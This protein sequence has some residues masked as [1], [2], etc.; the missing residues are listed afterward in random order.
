MQDFASRLDQQIEEHRKQRERDSAQLSDHAFP[1]VDKDR[2]ERQ[3]HKESPA[4]RQV[5]WQF[6]PRRGFPGPVQAQIDLSH[7][8]ALQRLDKIMWDEFALQDIF[9]GQPMSRYPVVY[10]E[11]LEEF[12]A[13]I[14]SDMDCSST[15]RKKRLKSWI[16]S[17]RRKA[18]DGKGGTLG[19]NLPGRGCFINGW[20]F[21]TVN[22]MAAHE[23]LNDA[24]IL[25]DILETTCH[26]KLG[27][28]FIAELT[29]MGEEKIDLGLWRFELAQ[30]FPFRT[31]DSPRSTLLYQKH[32]SIHQTSRFLEEGWATWIAEQMVWQAERRGFFGD[33]AATA[34]P[35]AC[36]SPDQ[37]VQLL[38][39]LCN[40]G[41]AD[42]RQVMQELFKAT[43]I[44]LAIAEQVAPEDVFWAMCFWQESAHLLNDCFPQP[45]PYVL[46]YLLLRRLEARL[47]WQ[48]VPCAVAIAANVTYNLEEISLVDLNALVKGDPRL[49]VDARLALLGTL[50]LASG[51]GPVDLA[52]LA[53]N[54]LSLAVPQG[55]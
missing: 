47:G 21:G 46:G 18:R 52:H 23:A 24:S 37:V 4:D 38:L 40:Q 42:E 31:V 26:E 1:S 9:P 43:Q 22:D 30:D 55:W 51:Q 44:L 53:R 33:K 6:P 35:Q 17:A 8:G 5:T 41:S 27:H 54:E 11:T 10:C 3:F 45:A 50:E 13:P 15:E 14:L 48:N 29:A 2:P 39:S 36:Y 34:Q 28:G 12:I 16:A 32:L 7:D 25:P 49:N 19:V 20:L